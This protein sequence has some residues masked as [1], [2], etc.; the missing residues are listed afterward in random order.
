M[1]MDTHLTWVVLQFLVRKAAVVLGDHA[2]GPGR[3]VAQRPR[4]ETSWSAMWK[5]AFGIPG[6]WCLGVLGNPPGGRFFFLLGADKV[7][8]EGKSPGKGC[9]KISF[10]RIRWTES[11]TLSK[12]TIHE[13]T[14]SKTIIIPLYC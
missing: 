3:F 1:G 13:L 6:F 9:D 8:R 14:I 7:C 2:D 11:I 12:T 10:W 5:A 4:H